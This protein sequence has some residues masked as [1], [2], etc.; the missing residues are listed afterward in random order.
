MP[1]ILKPPFSL[2]GWSISILLVFMI[3]QVSVNVAIAILGYST[4][5][6]LVLF[7]WFAVSAA[8]G[9]ALYT[10]YSPDRKHMA[11]L[12]GVSCFYV[13]MLSV[14]LLMKANTDV[15]ARLVATILSTPV[16]FFITGSAGFWASARYR[17]WLG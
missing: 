13:L 11:L 14:S 1:V 2:L 8:L 7:T 12:Q 10:R 6:L 16:A 4:N 9:F 15:D 3:L 5:P 17:A